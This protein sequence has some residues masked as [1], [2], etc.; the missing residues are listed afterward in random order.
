MDGG[1]R[2]REREV[3]LRALPMFW[4]CPLAISSRLSWP[5]AELLCLC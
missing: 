5:G 3:D 2:E 4:I 1:E